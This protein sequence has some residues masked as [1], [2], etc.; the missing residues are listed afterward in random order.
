MSKVFYIKETI[1]SF[2]LT[3]F[4]GMRTQMGEPINL[5]YGVEQPKHTYVPEEQP[6]D[7]FVWMRELKV[8]SLHGVKQHVYLEG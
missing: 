3:F 7:Q 8:S 2:L 4:F 1:L 5:E 6:A